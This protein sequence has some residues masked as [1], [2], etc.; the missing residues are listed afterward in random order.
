M[1]V[2]LGLARRGLGNCWPNPAVGCAL[3]KAG[4]VVGRGW[5]QPGGRPHAETEALARAGAAAR[6][7]TA[8]VTLEPCSHHG[9]TAPCVDALVAAGVRRVVVACR[10]PD[11]RVSGTGMGRLIA[12]G[13][14]IADDVLA[15]E[16]RAVA[17]GHILRI[18]Q[19]RP[20]V[21]LKTATSLDGRIATRTGDS[22]WIT[23]P[24]AR[25]TGHLLRAAHDAIL[26][27]IGTV[28]A[29]DP[30][31]TCRLA[32]VAKR[33]P[34]RV[35]LDSG[36]RFPSS[37]RLATEPADGP[38]WLFVKPG[39]IGSGAYGSGPIPDHIEVIETPSA[40]ERIDF[41]AVM[42]IL[43]ERGITRVLVEAGA[44]LTAS[45]LESGLVDTLYWF[46]AAR[47]IG[48]DGL[49]AAGPIGVERLADA[50]AY[51]LANSRGVGDDRLDV[52]WKV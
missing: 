5:T 17:R 49:A 24:A 38:V 52:Y 45:A 34:V 23:G 2:A 40:G 31:L 41:G 11:P 43:A 22:Q 46:R 42:H 8:Y 30:R 33:P 37:C 47:T 50:R 6:G 16:G 35:V 21:A 29:D 7:A 4:R 27:G 32:G 10:D 28:L 19:R 44:A 14:G 18:T 13:I 51:R 20:H 9:K 25:R 39:A 26:T 36:G 15:E 12:E 48:G 1:R 3:V